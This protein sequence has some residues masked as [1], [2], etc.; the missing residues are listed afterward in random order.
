MSMPGRA[1]ALS[2]A[3]LFA[4]CGCATAA[5]E[6]GTQ[7]AQAPAT[8]SALQTGAEI[9]QGEGDTLTVG[10]LPSQEL[11]AGQC[12]V[13]LWSRRAE[14]EFVFFSRLE[15]GTALMNINGAL[16]AFQRT[17]SVTGGE[18]ETTQVFRS[19]GGVSINLSMQTGEQ[20]QGGV[21]VPAASIRLTKKDGWDLVIPAAGLTAC[22]TG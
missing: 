18:G 10:A 4:A 5:Q 14:P 16:V 2:A 12:G 15:G 6:D 8:D 20:M 7:P 9:P 19:P 22:E 1:K 21:R 11:N 17:E 13:F 3:L